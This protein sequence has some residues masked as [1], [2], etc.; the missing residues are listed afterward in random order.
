MENVERGLLAGRTPYLRGGSGPR[1]ACVFFGVNA[2]F[3]RLDQ[4]PNPERYLRQISKLVPGHRITVLGY[5]SSSYEEILQDMALA[6]VEPPDIL[7]GVSFGGF[8][9]LRFAAQHPALVKQL[10][11]LVSA[12]RFSTEGWRRMERQFEALEQGDISTL[13]RE[14]ALLFRRPW[15]NWLVQLKLWK[16]RDRMAAGLRDPSAILKDYRELF[17]PEFQN[18]ADYAKRVACPTLIIGGGDDQFFDP[19]ACQETAAQI[20]RASVRI[21]AGETHMLPIEKSSEVARLIRAFAH[22][23]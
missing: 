20:S 7:L 2:L 8:V 10:A 22:A 18:N 3:R 23:R 1:T 12:H 16:D 5:A 13:I 4:T 6:M 17:G 14:N 21:V 15:Y 19:A 11:L 9:A